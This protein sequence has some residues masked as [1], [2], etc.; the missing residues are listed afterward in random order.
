M[1]Y[2][3]DEFFYFF[4][5]IYLFFFYYRSICIIDDGASRGRTRNAR[6]RARRTEMMA[7][8]GDFLFIYMK[9]KNLEKTSQLHF[10]LHIQKKKT[11][12][13]TQILCH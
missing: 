2:N 4:I 11:Q 3:T 5:F 6:F 13:G 12:E 7:S 8:A 10:K 9:L 1:S